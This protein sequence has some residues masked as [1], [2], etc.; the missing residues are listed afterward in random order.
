MCFLSHTGIIS[1][2]FPLILLFVIV[3][4][5]LIPFL[6]L[7]HRFTPLRFRLTVPIFLFVVLKSLF[8]TQLLTGFLTLFFG[9]LF[10]FESFLTLFSVLLAPFF[11]LFVNALLEIL[12][13]FA[14]L[15]FYR[16][17]LRVVI[18]C[19]NVIGMIR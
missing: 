1:C 3:I 12:R 14:F 6:F 10:L 17:R 15:F 13:A 11:L 16:R 5:I 7:L 18:L 19:R 4:Q 2:V 8:L 9:L